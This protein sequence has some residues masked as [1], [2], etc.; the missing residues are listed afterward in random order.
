MGKAGVAAGV[1]TFI[2][3]LVLLVDDLHDFVAGTDFLH[4]LP[5]FDP[6]I[7]WGFHLH[8]LY[9]GAL[10]MLIGLAIAAKYR[11]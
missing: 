9:I 6:Y 7:I 4:F 2:F 5:D 1:L 10:I 3:G 11:E 8:H